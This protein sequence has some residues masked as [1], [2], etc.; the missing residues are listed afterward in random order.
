MIVNVA[1]VYSVDV[2]NFTVSYDVPVIS[3]IAGAGVRDMD[4]KGGAAFSLTASNTGP[5]TI[6]GSSQVCPPP[7]VIYGTCASGGTGYCASSNFTANFG[8]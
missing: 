8:H 6:H 3:A 1:G 5:A 2:S 7:V 4:T